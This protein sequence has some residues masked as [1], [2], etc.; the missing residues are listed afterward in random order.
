MNLREQFLWSSLAAVVVPVGLAFAG[1]PFWPAGLN[2]ALCAFVGVTILQ[3]FVRGAGVRKGATGTDYLTAMVGLVGRSKRRY[4]GYIVHLGIVLMFFGFT[5]ETFKIDEQVML[6]PGQQAK[7]GHYVLRN[8]GVKITDDGQKQ[9]ITGHLAVLRDGKE[10]DKAYPA[11]W[12]YRKHEQEP[13]SQVAIRR[14]AAEDLYI[15]MPGFDP[16]EQTV[17]LQ[18]VIN[19][20][21]DW[22]WV[23][24]GVLALGTMIALLPE[25]AFSFAM[26]KLPAP[27]GTA[28][29]VLMLVLLRGPTVFAQHVEDPKF[30]PVEPKSAL[31]KDLHKSIIC[32][33]GTCGRQL[34]GECTCGYAAEMRA[35]ISNLVK[36]GMTRDQVIQY[37]INKYGSQE[38]L[39]E[40]IDKGFNR[41][42]WL[43]PYV[44]GA[45]GALVIGF[46]AI[47][48][49]RRPK[50]DGGQASPAEAG[51]QGDA[52]P[53]EDTADP[54]LEARLDDELRDLD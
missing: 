25:Q 8:D 5:G 38:P 53:K 15:V 18:V 28:M 23:G 39:A 26:A 45:S 6:K 49:S 7:I 29:L 1:V 46:A 10:I 43:F 40:P 54:Q 44:L 47:R 2:F 41:L 31:E 21:V 9:M 13:V 11:K 30:K 35:E 22:I 27:A 16:Q 33:C 20:L 48:W 3:E 24:F 12:F 37:Y 50:V 34:V 19:P 52:L 14:S 32:M 4:G 51:P 42:A 36:M 17:S